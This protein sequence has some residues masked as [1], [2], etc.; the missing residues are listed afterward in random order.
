MPIVETGFS[1]GN[2]SVESHALP[3]SIEEVE[4]SPPI[5]GT[6]LPAQA[7]LAR[8]LDDSPEVASMQQ[9]G[10]SASEGD[11]WML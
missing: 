1:S 4:P 9:Q 2:A 11:A 7:P 8:S 10:S 6:A 3:L 5:S